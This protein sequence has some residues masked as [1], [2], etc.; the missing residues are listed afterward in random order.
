MPGSIW[1]TMD[2]APKDGTRVLLLARPLV[3]GGVT[4]AMVVGYCSADRGWTD[5]ILPSGV[6]RTEIELFP[7]RW[8]KIPPPIFGIE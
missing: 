8:M 4:P 7:I 1:M 5:A 6:L 2:S 3:H